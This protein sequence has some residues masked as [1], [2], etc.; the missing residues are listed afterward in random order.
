M[1]NIID[2]MFEVTKILGLGG[3]RAQE[4]LFIELNR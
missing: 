2:G 1:L 3:E 4:C